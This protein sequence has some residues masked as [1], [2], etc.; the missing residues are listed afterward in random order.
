[1][2]STNTNYVSALRYRALNPLYDLVMR[3]TTRE[4]TIK[5]ALLAQSDIRPGFDVLDIGCG[6][7]TLTF[8]INERQADAQVVGLD[9]DRAIL[10]I[11]ARKRRNHDQ[12]VTF[13][14]GL[15]G[16]LPFATQ[17]FDRVLCSLLLHHLQPD[18]KAVTLA[19]IHRVLRPGG[20]LHIADWGAASGPITRAL[21]KPVQALDG[22]PNTI[23]HVEGR[24]PQYIS[25]AGFSD[26]RVRRD[27]FTVFGI[28][29]LFSCIPDRG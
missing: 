6:T 9:G 8:A 27:F 23:D 21:F 18:A 22:F 2:G 26:V 25:R 13:V 10:E 20:R 1:M 12:N 16:D 19:E 5:K 11:A 24:L 29:S 7:G 17:S 3:L 14:E 28:V 4:R 15:C